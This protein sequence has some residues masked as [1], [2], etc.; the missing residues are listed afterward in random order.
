[1]EI[2]KLRYGNTSTF[3][4]PGGLLV[5]T[6]YAG[7]LSAFYK[8]LKA[9]GIRLE[10]ISHV[11]ATHY[12]P[13]HCGLIGEIQRHG[14]KLILMESQASSVHYADYIFERDRLP[15]TPIDESA[16]DLIS[17]E[18]SREYLKALGIA[19]EIIPTRSHSTDSVSIV[20]DNGDCIAG[21]LPPREL[22]DGYHDHEALQ[23]DWERIISRHPKR[24][25]FAHMPGISEVFRGNT[26]AKSEADNY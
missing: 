21:D 9:N 15:Y 13:D 12:H 1:M 24:I 20:L 22:I 26:N 19:G 5:D 18:K 8:A 16:A 3:F 6:D 17:F 2:I 10:H 14:I 23:A 11:M 4:I 25:L 7:T